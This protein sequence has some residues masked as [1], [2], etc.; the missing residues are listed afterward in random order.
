M[1]Q[2]ISTPFATAASKHHF[3]ESFNYICRRWRTQTNERP[4]NCGRVAEI[5]FR[6]GRRR[7]FGRVNST[8]LYGNAS[9]SQNVKCLRNQEG[10]FFGI[11][12]IIGTIHLNIFCYVD[13]ANWTHILFIRLRK[14]QLYFNPSKCTN[15]LRLS[16]KNVRL[17]HKELL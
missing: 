14:S 10:G 16:S 1:Y 11:G 6:S 12:L 3:T 5:C 15:I 8:N 17:S 4:I 2:H 13:G 9:S 7:I